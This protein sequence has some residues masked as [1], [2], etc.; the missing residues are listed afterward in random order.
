MSSH[1]NNHEATAV[2]DNAISIINKMTQEPTKGKWLESLVRDVAPHLR[3][4]DIAQ[5]YSWADWPERKAY[6]PNRNARDTGI[7]LV[8]IRRSDSK[9][10]AI[11]CKARQ[12]KPGAKGAPISK[13]ELDKFIGAT[14]SEAIWAERWLVVNGDC[15]VSPN[16]N[17]E[18]QVK[19][20]NLH[21]DLASQSDAAAGRDAAPCPHC[22]DPSLLQTRQCMQ[23]EAVRESVRILREHTAVDSSGLPKGQ[24]RGRLI[25]PCGTGKTRISLRIVEDLTPPGQLAVVLCPSIAL[26]AQLR[27]EYLQC[28][29]SPLR[30]L[31]VCSDA[32]AG[33]NPGRESSRNTL[34]DPTLDTGNVS[35]REV[36]GKVTTDPAKSPHLSGRDKTTATASA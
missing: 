34:L 2:I 6:F 17:Q 25:L 33:Y 14:A 18:G 22:D 23:D 1:N 36:K 31:S 7:D 21:A 27:R 13:T 3:E 9:P 12:I 28:A 29:A 16:T 30:T 19:I 10:I 32:T 24:A 20:V 35:A 8:A 26:V 5:C 11:Q 4:W 15:P